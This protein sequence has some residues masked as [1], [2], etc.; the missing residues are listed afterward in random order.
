MNNITAASDM[1]IAVLPTN[2]IASRIDIHESLPF[3]WNSALFFSD[4]ENLTAKIKIIKKHINSSRLNFSFMGA[5]DNKL[6]DAFME[7]GFV[8]N[9]VDSQILEIAHG[10]FEKINYYALYVIVA[11]IL[12]GINLNIIKHFMGHLKATVITSVSV[13]LVGPFALIYLLFFTDFFTKMNAVPDFW[14]ATFYIVLLGVMSTAIALV[15]FNK[16][17]QLTTPIFTSSVTYMIPV[18]AIGWGVFDGEAL[19]LTHY[20]GIA[21]ILGGIYLV[22]R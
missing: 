3:G 22:N 7:G 1:S 11:T 8:E 20:I 9:K 21:I 6:R 12:Y 5:I 17:V 15:M 19:F 2:K 18:V 4:Y 13:L 16:L 10:N 14:L